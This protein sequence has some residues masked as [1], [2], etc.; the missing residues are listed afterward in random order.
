MHINAYIN[1]LRGRVVAFVRSFIISSLLAAFMRRQVLSAVGYIA[2]WSK[3]DDERANI[4][5]TYIYL[6]AIDWYE[7]Q[8]QKVDFDGYSIDARS[9][10]EQRHLVQIRG[11]T[12]TS[13]ISFANTY[14]LLALNEETD[15]FLSVRIYKRKIVGGYLRRFQIAR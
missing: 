12:N 2:W 15:I 11:D 4:T 9:N 3:R 5:S 7:C 6:L 10:G 8:G 1:L 13:T 14:E